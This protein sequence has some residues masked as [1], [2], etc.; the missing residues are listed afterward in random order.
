[1]LIKAIVTYRNKDGVEFNNTMQSEKLWIQP[2]EKEEKIYMGWFEN[3][4][5]HFSEKTEPY[6]CQTNLDTHCKTWE[7][8]EV[9]GINI[10]ID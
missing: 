5:K 9:W 7:L 10:I 2:F 1:L 3:V 8:S 4:R 6:Y